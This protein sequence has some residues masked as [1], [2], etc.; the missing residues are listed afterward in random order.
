MI[1]KKE[2]RNVFFILGKL[3]FAIAAIMTTAFGVIKICHYCEDPAVPGVTASIDM[4]YIN[5]TFDRSVF[6]LSVF[7]FAF[8]VRWIY[9]K[10]KNNA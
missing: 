10:S 1:S 5:Q 2:I 4:A 6:L 8:L 7:A 9:Q 3:L